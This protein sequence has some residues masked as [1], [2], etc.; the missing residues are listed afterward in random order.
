MPPGMRHLLILRRSFGAYPFLQSRSS[1]VTRQTFVLINRIVKN[2][3]SE[4]RSKKM[5]PSSINLSIRRP[6]HYQRS[7][8]KVHITKK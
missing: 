8:I 1:R 4:E 5:I 3:T 2:Q 6:S 7:Q